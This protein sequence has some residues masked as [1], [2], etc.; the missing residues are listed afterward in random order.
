MGQKLYLKK[1][2]SYVAVKKDC[3]S[4]DNLGVIGSGAAPGGKGVLDSKQTLCDLIQ[5]QGGNLTAERGF[6]IS[7]HGKTSQGTGTGYCGWK[8]FGNYEA[9]LRYLCQYFTLAECEP[10]DDCVVQAKQASGAIKRTF[11]VNEHLGGSQPK[12]TNQVEILLEIGFKDAA[13]WRINDKHNKRKI[14]DLGDDDEIWNEL[15]KPRNALYAFCVDTEVLYIGKTAR[16]LEKRFVGY[17]DPGK[18]RATNC[19][20]HNA[21]R[22][23]LKAQ[24]TVR[25][26]V[27]LDQFHLRWGN[28]HINLAAGLEDSLVETLEPK[29]NGNNGKELKTDSQ[30][31]EEKAAAAMKT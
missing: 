14:L 11:R 1:L 9:A 25:I 7:R 5:Q 19:R 6:V 26:M 23:L 24:K 20:C 21:I 12:A 2:R 16:S 8:D 28:F 4:R 10:E 3:D 15:K 30:H 29:L 13:Q 27:L 17:R 31:F 18:T 22:K